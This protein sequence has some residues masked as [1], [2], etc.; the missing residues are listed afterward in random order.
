MTTYM[1]G[2]SLAGPGAVDQRAGGDGSTV[3]GRADGQSPQQ[4]PGAPPGPPQTPLMVAGTGSY[5]W[6]HQLSSHSQVRK[7]ALKFMK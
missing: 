7:S 1:M 4:G 2:M 3:P 6:G 5:Y